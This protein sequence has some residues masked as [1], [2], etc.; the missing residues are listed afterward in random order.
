MTRDEAAS[1]ESGSLRRREFD[2]P[3]TSAARTALAI[4]RRYAA[5]SL[6]NHA[7]R[8]YPWGVSYAVQ[9]NMRYDQELFYVAAILHDLGLERRI[10][11][12]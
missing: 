11:R 3:Q 4:T 9:H 1:R 7:R 5:P 10:D 2:E 8:S 12:C 6:F